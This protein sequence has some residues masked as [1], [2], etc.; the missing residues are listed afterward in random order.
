MFDFIL[1]SPIII[2]SFA[3]FFL[4][5]F[6]Y[7]LSTG[8]QPNSVDTQPDPV[9]CPKCTRKVDIKDAICINCGSTGK[10]HRSVETMT[11]ITDIGGNKYDNRFTCGACG[12]SAFVRCPFCNTNITKLMIIHSDYY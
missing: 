2:I 1:S 10:I 12:E 11:V 8:F 4:L 3:V 9:T 7:C 6:V 5:L